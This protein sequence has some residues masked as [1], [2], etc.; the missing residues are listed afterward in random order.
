MNIKELNLTPTE[1]IIIEFNGHKININK[2]ISESEKLYIASQIKDIYFGESIITS[3]LTL[4]NKDLKNTLIVCF[5]INNYTDIDTESMDY[6]DAC[7]MVVTSGLYD[8]IIKS[9]P[10]NEL[11]RLTT[12]IDNAIEEKR[13]ELTIEN[14]IE[15]Q[16]HNFLNKVI[17]NMSEKKLISILKKFKKEMNGVKLD[18]FPI[19]KDL[20]KTF[21]NK[22][23]T[24]IN[25]IKNEIDTIIETVKTK[26]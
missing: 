13:H 2:Y 10:K 21:G 1:S 12:S 18:D 24:D 22:D 3:A 6:I 16:L 15:N 11:D 20:A 4:S 5:I 23:M 14:S 8:E 25:N 7:D 26:K 17:E 9:I 19:L